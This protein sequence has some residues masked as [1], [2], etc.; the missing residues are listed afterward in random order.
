MK[1]FFRMLML[2]VLAMLYT[3]P[4]HAQRLRQPTGRAVV[5]T[6]RSGGRSVT[7]SG[8]QGCLISWRKLA[9][10]ADG[11]T[12]NV[13][14][15]TAGAGEYVKLNAQPLRVTCYAPSSLTNN[16]EYAVTAITP[17]GVEGPMSAPFLY[18]SQPWPNVWLNIDFD[19]TVLRRD[20]YR[21]K[22]TWPMDLD[23]DGTY[24]ALV[25]D[26]LFAG[27]ISDDAENPGD[28][29]ATTTHKLQAYRFTGE[30]LWTI[31][32]GPNVNIC[33]GQNDM[34]VAWDINCDGR[35]EVMVRSSDGTRFWD[36]ANNTWGL[37]AM[38]S[39]VPDVDG[40]GIVD[41]RTQSRR[42]RPFYVSVIDG[43]T[44]AEIACSELKYAEVSDGAD[45]YTRDN[46]QDY[47]SDGYAAMDG[48]FAICY[49][50]GI[51]P[52]LVMECLDRDTQK[53]HHNY[54]FTWEY[55]WS[56]GHPTNWHHDK[57]WSRNDKR[58]WPAEFHQLRVADVDGDGRDEMIQGGYSVN[59]K[60]GWFQSPGIGHG[61]RFILSDIDPD[62][63]G[64]EVYAIQQS[65]LLGQ[66]IY[67]ACTA[68]RIKEWYLPSVY[69][70][71]RGTC[72]DMD[73]RFKGYE[74]FSYTDDYVY[75]C[76]GEKTGQTRS[77]SMFEGLWWDGD[78]LREWLNS[79]GGSGWG[80]N[81]MVSKV[82]GDRLAEFSSESNWAAH[83][84]TGTR[85]TFMG[86]IMGDWREEVILAKQN[87]QGSTGLVGY[88]TAM[89]TTY[90]IY[91]LQQD[92]HYSGDCTTRGY[93]QHPNTGFYLGADMPQPPLP[94]VFQT[95]LRWR[96]GSVESGFTSFDMTAD[97]PL[98]DGKSLMFDLTGDNSQPITLSQPLNA[99]AIFLMNPL[100][101]D[102]TFGGEGT[103]GTGSLVKSMQGTATFNADL[104]HTGGT[105]VSE[106]TLA[107]HGTIGGPVEL[108]ARGTLAG[109]PTLQDTITFEGALNHE[110]CRLKPE[111]HHGTIISKKSM[112]L[113][114]EVYLEID[115]TMEEGGQPSCGQLVVEGDLT[116]KGTNHLTVN[117]ESPDGAT[118]VIATCSGKL[119]C[120]VSKLTTRGLDGLNYDLN[121]VD[122]KQL[123]LT[124]HASRAPQQNVVWTGSESNTWNYKAQ[125]FQL[126]GSP[127]AFVAGDAVVFNA[128]GQRTTVSVA[129]M[130]S[131]NGVTFDSGTYTLSGEGGISG[132]GSL[133]VNADAK[134]TLNMKNSDYTGKT[135]VNGGTLTIPN[136]YD[137]GQKSALGAATAAAGN[138]Q[139]NGGTLILSR[140][141][142]GTDRQITLTDTATIRIALQ[143][144]SLSLKGQVIGTGQLVKDGPGQLNFNYG[145]TNTFAGIIVRK[146]IVAQGAWNSTFGR[147]GSPML[148]AGGEV[149]Q[150]DVNNTSTVPTLNHIITVEEGTTN[151]IVGSSRGKIAGSVKGKGNLTI[152]TKY[153]RCD[154][155]TNFS[156]FEGQLTAVG[157]GGNF[158]LMAEV[159]DMSKA[160]LVVGA[161]TTVSH[162]K[163]GS[164]SEATATTRIGALSATAADAVL[165]GSG[166]TYQIGFRN[167]DT[168]FAGKFTAAKI[169][170]TG[171]GKLTLT[172]TG[173][174]APITVS[175]GM[176]EMTNSAS[177]IMASGLIT[178]AAGGQLSGTGL[179][180]SVNVQKGGNVRGG[181]QLLPTGN[182]RLNGNLSLQQG[183]TTLLTLGA[184]TGN[185]KITVA[186]AIRHS[187]DTLL[188][189]VPQ[190][191]TLAMGDV[192]QVY[193]GFSSATG[194]VVVKCETADGMAYEFDTSTLN[195]D[196]SITVTAADN[197]AATPKG[198]DLVEVY[199]THGMKMRSAVP[200]AKALDGLPA[201]TYV[202]GRRLADGRFVGQKRVKH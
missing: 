101:H 76:K 111:G 67:D 160:R 6:Q 135:I 196:G 78:L 150:I 145:G 16:A 96:G 29:V 7:A 174:T 167:E 173:H 123:V 46:R 193:Q 127:T 40:D 120:D 118:Y 159:T 68:E 157:L 52:S 70:V 143:N 75:T 26:R 104:G 81:M 50:D 60:T 4:S 12:W 57:T 71:G 19:N 131:T 30:L 106:G 179:L 23:G 187:N 122:D 198:D 133:I 18:K 115:A 119:T 186:G 91:C 1:A 108:R 165:G 177:T 20:D 163:G 17:D 37:Y 164:G 59:P 39:S 48:H 31:D 45:R 93:Y 149:R 36:K 158:R 90:T 38:G 10:E 195:T 194:D 69:D 56:G 201:G 107:V 136:F 152:E 15:R 13:Y 184:T 80:T 117:L 32:M 192:I 55:D 175:G 189:S 65:A 5:A 8:G 25:A 63:P 85:P 47:M 33:G 84:G 86:D 134:V 99:P 146:G 100:G 105:I 197:I 154:V 155:G 49:L 87:D 183:A 102:Y 21:T 140:D 22:Y 137:G 24:D 142:M 34:V 202:V 182:L 53:T 151:K 132:E 161:G 180:Q 172:G 35:C 95:D 181:Y 169:E 121:V 41:Y 114:G 97:S 176:L 2:V 103:T 128:E 144:S 83:G 27:A 98:A 124:I 178:V 9:E 74:L 62:R 139:L 113:P 72:L 130:M 170:K 109:T 191:R 11:T 66:L 129:E 168:R 138:L 42:N 162:M 79:P 44:G 77:G 43:E 73:A 94:P 51:H 156:Q 110:G 14:R 112:T 166:S 82:L 126:A 200:M 147:I 188:V 171:T 148:L 153:V 58:P 125:N 141:N 92:P 28:N 89:P 88:T 190:G 3:I 199:D 64:L 54:V 185:S 61:D 116:L